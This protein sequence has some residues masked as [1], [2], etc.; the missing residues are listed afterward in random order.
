MDRTEFHEFIDAL[1]KHGLRVK[2]LLTLLDRHTQKPYASPY[3]VIGGDDLQALRI[4][5][6]TGHD[7]KKFNEISSRITN[8]VKANNPTPEQAR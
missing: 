2:E 4:I 3:D 6:E 1:A 5:I 8:G 7:F